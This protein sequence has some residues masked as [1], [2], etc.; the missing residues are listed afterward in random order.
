MN[1][2][3]TNT[4]TTTDRIQKFETKTDDDLYNEMVEE[5]LIKNEGFRW[6]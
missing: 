1:T 6:I 3:I 5:E 4:E 2:A